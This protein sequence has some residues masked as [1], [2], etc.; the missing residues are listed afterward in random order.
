VDADFG[1]AGLLWSSEASLFF[2][3]YRAYDPQL[4]RWM[5]RDPLR[6][7]EKREGPNLYAYVGNEPVNNTDPSGL[8][9]GPDT[10]TQTCTSGPQ[11]LAVCIA[12]GEQVAE[13][14]E[15]LIPALE[16]VEQTVANCAP[17][18]VNDAN[19]AKDRLNDL[20]ERAPD[21]VNKLEQY[22]SGDG[23][24]LD[25]N[26]LELGVN[27]TKTV[28]SADGSAIPV[29]V[30]AIPY[31]APPEAWVDL[32]NDA[33]ALAPNIANILARIGYAGGDVNVLTPHVSRW[34]S[35]LLRLYPD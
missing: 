7:A 30:T 25:S 21:A 23:D 4:G 27:Y 34:L 3:R 9:F 32:G 17:D 15:G 16:N 1:Y 28:V 29:D 18:L 20:A 2:A 6:N 24:P 11:G 26:Y 5:S 13:N 31:G 14:S 35:G 12:I 22:L 33:D 8:G 10:V 19:I